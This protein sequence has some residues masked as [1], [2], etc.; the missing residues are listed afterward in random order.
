MAT[1]EWREVG[2]GSQATDIKKSDPGTTYEGVFLAKRPIETD[3]G[4][5][6]IYTFEGPDGEF[7]VYG[8]TDLDAKLS[9]V[10]LGNEV[11]M[12]YEGRESVKTKRGLVNMHRVKVEIAG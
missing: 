8:F 11:R 4:T 7:S 9:Q 5:N 1:K 12:T 10:V 3:Y 6:T 2:F